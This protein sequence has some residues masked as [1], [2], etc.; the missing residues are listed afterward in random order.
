MKLHEAHTLTVDIAA[1]IATVV[2]DLANP[3]N[4]PE[5]ATEFFAGPAEA[6]DRNEVRVM[7]PRLG[8]KGR[9]RIV[10]H[11]QCG[12]VDLY[13][14][15]GDAPYGEPIPVRIIPNG[16]GARVLWTLH[17]PPVS[18]P[19]WQQGLLS[20]ERELANLKARLEH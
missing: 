9:M 4:H 15:P 3:I 7:V 10:S 1:P 20:M 16:E 19:E 18:E 8:G 14:A 5:W 6:I 11:I 12:L 17:R 2:A 13:L